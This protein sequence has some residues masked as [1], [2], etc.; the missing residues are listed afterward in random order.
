MATF[1]ARLGGGLAAVQDSARD[2]EASARMVRN[3]QPGIIPRLLQTAGYACRIMA[4]ADTGHHGSHA[5]AVAA[6][7]GHQ[8]QQQPSPR[9]LA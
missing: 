1:R 9:R 5:A 8:Q 6:R 2:P 3:Y 7:L 4:L